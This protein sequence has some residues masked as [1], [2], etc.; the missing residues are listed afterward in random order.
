MSDIR[1][2][3]KLDFMSG[4]ETLS[5]RPK[6]NALTTQA[7]VQAGREVGFSERGVGSKLDGR[8]L[9]S[10]GANIQLNIKITEQEKAEILHDASELIQDPQSSVTNI[11]EFVVFAVNFYRLHR[12][13]SL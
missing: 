4:I 12:A 3:I 7:S 5:P 9:R 8:K 10:R 1:P 13:G 2:A 6:V 11:G